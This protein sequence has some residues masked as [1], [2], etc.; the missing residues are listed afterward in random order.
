MGQ[1][2]DAFAKMGGG[3]KEDFR[4]LRY[5]FS[6]RSFFTILFSLALFAG[7][8]YLFVASAIKMF[9][10]DG[11]VGWLHFAGGFLG[12]L[13]SC[14]LIFIITVHFSAAPQERGEEEDSGILS[15]AHFGGKK[16]ARI[17]TV[18]LLVLITFGAGGTALG[19]YYSNEIKYSGYPQTEATV[20]SLINNGNDEGYTAVYEY[21]VD[22]KTYKTKG[23]LKGSGEAVPRIGDTV[24][25]KYNPDNPKEIYISTESKFLLGFGCFLIFFGL[26]VIVCDLYT[27]KLLKPQ[28]LLAFILLGLTACVFLIYLSSME[29]HGFIPFFARNFMLHFVLIFT[30]V[31]VLEL[32]NGIV[33]IGYKK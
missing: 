27:A 4:R 31:G 32:I 24:S 33:Y 30:N 2:K 15:K 3:I 28:F 13:V 5:E 16:G 10:A 29:F 25:I 11:S 6:V 21:T 7:N 1:L 17:A 19:F 8:I 23:E 18:I 20:V 14:F 26:T 12:F 9:E 22:G